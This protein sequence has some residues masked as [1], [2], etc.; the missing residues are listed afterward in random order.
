MVTAVA[1]CAVAFGILF[2][3]P[4]HTL[5]SDWWNLPDAGH[6]LLLGPTS[7]W[8]AWR[9]G[10]AAAAKSQPALGAAILMTAVLL[11]YA[12]GLAAEPFAMRMA[13]V[14]ALM[15]LTVYV[16]GAR[17][18]HHWWVSFALLFL[19]IPLPELLLQALALPLQFQA[20]ELGASLLEM[21]RVP[22]HLAG[23]VIRIP[24]HELFVAEACSGLRSLTALISMAVLMGALFLRTATARVAIILVAIPVAIIVNGV[25]VFI[26]AYLLYVVDP[27]MGSGFMHATEGW[28]LFLG[29]VAVLAGCVMAG[30]LVER[31]FGHAY[32][33]A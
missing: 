3:Q 2:W 32:A 33:R 20:S 15:G 25:R 21:R 23:N 28:L 9:G 13:M 17:Q 27:A 19:S 24:G 7:I 1:A 31:R 18:V 29:S 12:G 16:A 26:T 10:R 8:L 5:L 22:V 30:G 11:R 14:G 4:F 6:G